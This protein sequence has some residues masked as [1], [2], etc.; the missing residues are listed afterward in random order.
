MIVKMLMLLNVMMFSTLRLNELTALTASTRC[1][2]ATSSVTPKGR[3][4]CASIRGTAKPKL[5]TFFMS[6]PGVPIIRVG[7]MT[8]RLPYPVNVQ[9]P[10]I[11]GPDA[12]TNPRVTGP[13]LDIIVPEDAIRHEKL[14]RFLQAWSDLESSLDFVLEKLVGIDLDDAALIMAKFG[15]KNALELLEGMALRKLFP[16]DAKALINLLERVGRLNT[17]RNILVH[18]RWVLEA[19][20]LLRRGEAYLATQFLR[21][22]IPTDPEDANKMANPRNQ[23]ER[24]RYTFT[25]KRIDATSRDADAFNKDICNFIQTMR[26]KSVPVG[27]IGTALLR[28][29]PYRV[30]YSTPRAV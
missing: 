27:E 25:L 5:G 18:G 10:P 2:A 21:E 6:F 28:K 7:Y 9:L 1:M 13:Q 14:G 12:R 16:D 24:V 20:V 29:Q 22:V 8:P 30:T 15:T 3:H 17:K 11:Q 19:N 23:K 26:Y 4:W